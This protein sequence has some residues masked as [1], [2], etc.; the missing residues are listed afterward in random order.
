MG[1]AMAPTM[2]LDPVSSFCSRWGL[3]DQSRQFLLQLPQVGDWWVSK[4][5][6]LK[7]AKKLQR[8]LELHWNTGMSKYM[9]TYIYIYIYIYT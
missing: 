1:M 4:R 5:G 9:C 8:D 3:S 7:G 2:Q 6:G